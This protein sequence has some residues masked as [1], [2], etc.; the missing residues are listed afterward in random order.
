MTVQMPQDTV[1][2]KVYVKTPRGH[3][4]VTMD[5]WTSSTWRKPWNKYHT[6]NKVTKDILNRFVQQKTHKGISLNRTAGRQGWNRR[7]SWSPKLTK[8]YNP[9]ALGL[10]SGPCPSHSSRQVQ[11]NKIRK[12]EDE[13]CGPNPRKR[14]R[15]ATPFTTHEVP[16]TISSD[17]EEDQDK[18]SPTSPP[19]HER[20]HS[21]V[22]EY[23]AKSPVYPPPSDS[24][25]DEDF[26]SM[27][28]LVTPEEGMS[29]VTD[30]SNDSGYETWGSAPADINADQDSFQDK[31]RQ[32]ALAQGLEKELHKAP[33]QKQLALGPIDDL[34]KITKTVKPIYEGFW[35]N[36][37]QD[38]LARLD[39]AARKLKE[40]RKA[41]LQDN[42]EDNKAMPATPNL[43]KSCSLC[44]E[45]IGYHVLQCSKEILQDTLKEVIHSTPVEPLM[46]LPKI[47]H[48]FPEIGPQTLL[49]P[50]PG[51]PANFSVK[52]NSIAK[53]HTG[54][55][56]KEAH[57]LTTLTTQPKV[58]L[59]R[60]SPEEIQSHTSSA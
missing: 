17:E 35:Y 46:G 33:W 8:K 30:H 18:T 48:P 13:K 5:P 6:P 16:L 41:Q 21:M 42:Q 1:D 49:P 38:I 37:D 2:S 51:I 60:M 25:D 36:S 9:R 47:V 10:I 58:I 50:L 7:S 26:S 14:A 19:D 54:P 12:E 34:K 43:E 53:M 15:E 55:P 45:P 59:K 32:K 11:L 28:D 29:P 31:D 24:S 40:R 20:G 57:I 22:H 56:P 44:D 52:L 27:P 4:A 3:S 23:Q 39:Q